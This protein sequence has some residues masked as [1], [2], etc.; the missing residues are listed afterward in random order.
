MSIEWLIIGAGLHGAHLAIRLLE[1]GIPSVR[2]VDPAG[3][4]ETWRTRTSRLA[5]S[6]LRSPSVHNIGVRP[7][8]LENFAGRRRGRFRGIYARPRLDL[9]NDHCDHLVKTYGLERLLIQDR[10]TRLDLQSGRAKAQLESGSTVSAEKVVLALGSPEPARPDRLKHHPHVFDDDWQP[11]NP[12]GSATVVGGGISAVQLALSL[13]ESGIDVELVSRHRIRE[14]NFDSDPCWLGPTCMDSFSR[15]ESMRSRRALIRK[16][17]NRG[18]VPPDIKRALSRA[19]QQKR[20]RLRTSQ[21]LDGLTG[22]VLLATGFATGRPGGELVEDLVQRQGLPV[23]PCGFP[24][25]SPTL[26]WDDRLWVCGA[27]AELELGPVARNI[28]GARRA[29]DRIVGGTQRSRSAA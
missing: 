10:V 3:F 27:L 1:R 29:A 9:F 17:R 20:V 8:D 28:A 12:R 13:S 24:I 23:A 18:T 25:L 6:H 16:A 26:R 4:F 11:P 22:P 19:K 15:V 2:V 14:A 21:H 7:M 5:M